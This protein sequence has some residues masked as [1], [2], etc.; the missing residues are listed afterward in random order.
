MT[1]FSLWF[2]AARPKTLCIGA[3]PVILSGCY[4]F[5]K[6]GMH[7]PFFLISL[8]GALF[9]QIGTNYSNDYYDFLLGADTSSRKG[10]YKLLQKKSVSLGQ[11]KQAFIICFLAALV[12]A[13]YLGYHLGPIY[14][15]IGTL[16][17]LFSLLYT[18]GP[19]PLAYTGLAD[20]F[21]LIFYGPVAFL[22]SFSL[23]DCNFNRS[24]NVLSLLP[25]LLGLG[26]LILNNLRDKETDAAVDKKTLIV[27]LGN[28]FGHIYYS[29]CHL[30]AF[31]LY[32]IFCIIE[33]SV[34]L[35]IPLG[36]FILYVPI[37]IR[38][39]K[40]EP[41]YEELF[42][43]NAKLVALLSFVISLSVFV[44]RWIK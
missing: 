9:I 26:P 34:V 43:I 1:S 15:T 6:E 44:T 3:F 13:G 12:C 21:V 27:R 10:S 41:V 37:I 36:L 38:L 35:F 18:A 14:L 4:A 5:S 30:I 23:H 42:I 19:F 31:L 29:I 16:C 39:W 8:L 28:G 33:S 25:G 11:M 7:L 32:L 2:Y 17:I 22:T 20:L 24:S 40:K